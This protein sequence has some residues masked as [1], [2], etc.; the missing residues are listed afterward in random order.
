MEK[1]KEKKCSYVLLPEDANPL[2][3]Y[4]A[5]VEVTGATIIPVNYEAYK[6][7]YNQT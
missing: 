4:V 1:Q 3:D 6:Q 7:L 2:P 5:A